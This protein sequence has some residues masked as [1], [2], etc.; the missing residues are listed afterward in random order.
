M[1]F[2]AFFV[3]NKVIEYKDRLESIEGQIKG[4]AGLHKKQKELYTKYPWLI[5]LATS[6]DR[7]IVG[8]WIEE[9][10]FDA[11]IYPEDKKNKDQIN[12]IKQEV[13]SKLNEIGVPLEKYSIEWDI[14]EQSVKQQKNAR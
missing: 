5:E 1:V 3:V 12:T 10:K 13:I 4:D 11:T 7:Y 8:F 6:T 2:L 14:S 9:E